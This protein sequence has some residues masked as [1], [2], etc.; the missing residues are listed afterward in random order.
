MRIA[1][2]IFGEKGSG[3]NIG[4]RRRKLPK[5]QKAME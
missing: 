5:K 2:E 1:I 4:N 3:E